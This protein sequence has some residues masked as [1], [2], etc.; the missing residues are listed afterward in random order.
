MYEEGLGVEKDMEEAIRLYKSV[1]KV[2]VFAQIALGRIYR[3]GKG[4]VADPGEALHYYAAAT[5]WG[6]RVAACE[7]MREAKEFVARYPK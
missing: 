6:D 1:S 7:E 3:N 2:E 5:E 4:V